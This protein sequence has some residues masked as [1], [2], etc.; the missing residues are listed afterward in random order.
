MFVKFYAP[1]SYMFYR[2]PATIASYMSPTRRA[3]FRRRSR[4]GAAGE[5]NWEDPVVQSRIVEDHPGKWSS[6][7]VELVC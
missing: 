6:L 2:K 3:L 7:F 5:R 4:F 1:Q